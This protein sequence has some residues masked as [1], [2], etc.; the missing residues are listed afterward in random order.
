MTH[1][2]KCGEVRRAPKTKCRSTL[3]RRSSL[4]LRHGVQRFLVA[5]LIDQRLQ[6]ATLLLEQNA[7]CVELDD[8]AG[9]Q[10]HL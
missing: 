4:A 1:F 3:R 9:V 5:T 2:A 10:N 6:E 7:R 8:A